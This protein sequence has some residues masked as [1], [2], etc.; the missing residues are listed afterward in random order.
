MCASVGRAE[1]QGLSERAVL[2]QH[3]RPWPGHRSTLCHPGP[4]LLGISDQTGL[5]QREQLCLSSPCSQTQSAAPHPGYRPGL[6]GLLPAVLD[7][8]AAASVP[9]RHA[10]DSAGGHAGD[11]ESHPHWADLRELLC[12]SIL[13]HAIDWKTKTQQTD[14]DISK[15]AVPQEQSTAVVHNNVSVWIYG[16]QIYEMVL[17]MNSTFGAKD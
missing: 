11:S 5:G 4:S 3:P 13:L 17:Y 14:A 10:A 16:I 7:L 12:E 9:A 1:L 6:L 8:A 2:H 15:S